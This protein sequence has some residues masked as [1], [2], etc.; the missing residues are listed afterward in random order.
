MNVMTPVLDYNQALSIIGN[1]STP[2]KMPW[3]GWSIPA[4]THCKTGGKLAEQPG[5]IC[6]LC[7]AAKGF[8]VMPNTKKA[9]N[10]RFEALDHPLFVTAFALVLNTLRSR[11]RKDENR[12]R[13]H[14]SGDLQ[15]VE[16][17]R[18]IN[19]IALLTPT[20]EH[21]LPTKEA[22]MVSKFLKEGNSF[23][24]NLHV[25][26]SHPMIGG[27]FS[28]KPPMGMSYTTAGRDDDS[29]MFQCPALRKQGNKCRDCRAC[30][31]SAN[32]NYPVH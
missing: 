9:L 24:P 2:S 22:G 15:N 14:D 10:R 21:F 29:S 31:T 11:Q 30:W 27:T 7:Y 3:Y 23:A 1:L 20:V 13:W 17:L 12:F 19:Q 6:S 8:Y 28:D 4:K 18:K 5:T 16:H 25:K 32:I 26:I